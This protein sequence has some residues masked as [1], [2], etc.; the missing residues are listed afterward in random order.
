MTLKGGRCWTQNSV[1]SLLLRA[2]GYDS[3][4]IISHVFT[5][6]TQNHLIVIIRHVTSPG[7]CHVADVACAIASP[8]SVDLGFETES[9][10]VEGIHTPYKYIKQ[11]GWFI[12]CQKY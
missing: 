7:S 12:R 1:L 6:D 11:N 2:L 8:V 4:V 3:Y 9:E 10:V 5:P